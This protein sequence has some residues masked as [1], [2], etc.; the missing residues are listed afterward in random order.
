M[1][2]TLSRQDPSHGAPE[3]APRDCLRA[4]PAVGDDMVLLVYFNADGVARY[5][6]RMPS[7]WLDDQ[8]EARILRT[9]RR[10]ETPLISIMR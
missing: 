4:Y 2:I 8:T 10:H 3:D 6:A 1:S 7:S 5:E 9:C